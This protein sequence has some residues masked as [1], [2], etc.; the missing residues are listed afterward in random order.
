[1]HLLFI[2]NN[3]AVIIQGSNF[4]FRSDPRGFREKFQQLEG[5]GCAVSPPLG[6]WSQNAI[7]MLENSVQSNTF[8]SKI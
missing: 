5:R 2:C 6:V 4:L 3:T 8:W 1:M 7:Q